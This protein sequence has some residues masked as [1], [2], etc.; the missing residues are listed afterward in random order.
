MSLWKEKTRKCKMYIC[1]SCHLPEVLTLQWEHKW[2]IYKFVHKLYSFTINYIGNVTWFATG[3]KWATM[4]IFG[5]WSRKPWNYSK[6][7][8]TFR[9]TQ[10]V[11]IPETVTHKNY[12]HCVISHTDTVCRKPVSKFIGTFWL[13]RLS[14]GHRNYMI[15]L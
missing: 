1:I 11:K 15:H 10:T 4:S 12:T 7:S 2:H 3:K 13:F 14:L 6:S 9:M 5:H 8:P